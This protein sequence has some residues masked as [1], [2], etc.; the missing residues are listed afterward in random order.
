MDRGLSAPQIF[1]LN[2]VLNQELQEYL[3][4]LQITVIDAERFPN[5]SPI[6]DNIVL[7]NSQLLDCH[8]QL[9]ESKQRLINILSIPYSRKTFF[10]FSSTRLHIEHIISILKSRIYWLNDTI[11]KLSKFL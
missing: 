1:E 8:N 10:L 9:A 7:F 4:F 5:T 11:T 3:T 2:S 6:K